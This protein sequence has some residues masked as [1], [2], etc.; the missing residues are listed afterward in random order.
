MPFVPGE[1]R[2]EFEAL[3]QRSFSRR[4]FEITD[5]GPNNQRMRAAERPAYYP[6]CYIQP[7][8]GNE[9][10]LGFDLMNGPTR[11][12][13]E[14]ARTIRRAV[15]TLVGAG[16]PSTRSIVTDDD[17]RFAFLGLPEG[18]YTAVATKAGFAPSLA[19][20]SRAPSAR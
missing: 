16:T 14:R 20:T 5:I 1:K 6:I 10:V 7:V 19:T 18:R 3:I 13:L 2:A 8:R 17:G 15:V 9:M 11:E 4:T 12:F